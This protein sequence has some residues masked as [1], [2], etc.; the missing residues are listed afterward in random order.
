MDVW[1]QLISSLG[2]PIACC[3]GMAWYVNKK[4]K[5]A[6][7]DREESNKTINSLRDAITNNTIVMHQII[8]KL[9]GK[10]K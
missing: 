7:A 8:E 9:G 10:E 5:E 1:T 6:R 4:D 2:F 3:I